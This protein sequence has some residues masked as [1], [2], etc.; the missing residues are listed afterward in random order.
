MPSNIEIKAYVKDPEGIEKIVKGLADG[1]CQVL[2]QEDFFFNSQRGRLKLRVFSHDSGHLI[3]YDRPDSAEAKQSGYEIYVTDRPLELQRI[4]SSSLGTSVVVKKK[5]RVYL[6]GQTRVHFDQV[7]G[8]GNFL[9]LEFVLGKNQDPEEGHIIID[10]LMSRLGID[11][12][13]LI[14]VAY[15]DMIKECFLDTGA[16]FSYSPPS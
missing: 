1:P 14:A 9:E 7:E 10:D 8:L 15:A 4:L 3:Y 11:K 12:S 2:D 6:M 16:C 13:D 5:R